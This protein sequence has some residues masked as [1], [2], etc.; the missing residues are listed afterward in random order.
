LIGQLAVHVQLVTVQLVD[1]LNVTFV[2]LWF[3]GCDYNH[4][5][6]SAPVPHSPPV[7]SQVLVK[8]PSVED[9]ISILRGLKEK[10]ES[11]HGVRILDRALVVAAQLSARYITGM[12][13]PV[14]K[15]TAWPN[16][17]FCHQ[18]AGE[19]NSVSD[20]S[21]LN[22]SP[23]ADSFVDSAFQALTWAL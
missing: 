8:E 10:Y 20:C 19:M 1:P 6:C 13:G 16:P 2:L 21:L 22:G 9:A 18:S 12:R 23:V 5:I 11:H 3:G 14:W 15:N 7:S 4:N 17:S